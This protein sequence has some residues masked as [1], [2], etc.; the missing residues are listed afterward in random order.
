[1][2]GGVFVLYTGYENPRDFPG[3]FVVRRWLADAGGVKCERRPFALGS[4][5]ES[6][7]RLLPA[8]LHCLPRATTDDP[9]IVET[10]V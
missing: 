10:W 3:Q 1:M 5:L 7:R 4:T 2:N 6:V 8:G 9:V